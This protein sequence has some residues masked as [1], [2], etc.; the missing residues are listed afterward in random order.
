MSL[1]FTT[2]TLPIH[3]LLTLSSTGSFSFV[4]AIGYV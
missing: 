2:A 1:T 4:P 3:G